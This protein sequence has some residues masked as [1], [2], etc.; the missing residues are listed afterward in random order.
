[1]ATFTD[2]TKHSV[3]FTN[4]SANSVTMTSLTK[5]DFVYFLDTETGLVIN[6]EN[7]D[8]LLAEQPANGAAFTN[9]T[10]H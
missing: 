9:L 8:R 4:Q 6:A 3:T 5:I 2:A 10:K 7:N 1:M